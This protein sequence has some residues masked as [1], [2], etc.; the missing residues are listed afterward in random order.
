MSAA[1][2]AGWAIDGLIASTLLLGAVMLVRRHV[3][4]GF[5]AQLA[6]C[7]WVLPALRLLL[8]PLPAGWW[9]ASADAPITRAG[10]TVT[11][12]LAH[13]LA[14]ASR[15]VD[16]AASA[17]SPSML[18][19]G[20]WAAGA[21]LF[22]GWHL[23]RHHRFCRAV[24]RD[25]TLL[26][27]RD[28]IRIVASPAA[29]GPIAFGIVRR[30]VAFP[31][32]FATRYDAGEQALALRHELGHHRRRDL[33]ANWAAL[34]V[35]ALHWFNPLAWAAFRAF[36][37]DQEL[38][39]DAGVLAGCSADERHAYARAIVK[40]AH[41][42]FGGGM[43]A[44]HLHTVTDLKGRL[45]MLAASRASRRRLVAGAATVT[46]LTAA[47][48][49]LT[50]SGNAAERIGAT[51]QASADAPAPAAPTPPAD[52]GP[53]GGP[54]PVGPTGAGSG[55]RHVET[56]RT[57]R[58]T[59]VVVTENG[60]TR[61]FEGAEAERYLAEHRIAVPAPPAPPAPPVSSTR[62]MSY[63]Y[64]AG[65]GSQQ[66]DVRD[67]PEMV[68]VRCGTAGTRPAAMTYAD[69]TGGKRK[70]VVC[71]DRIAAAQR[72]AEEVARAAVGNARASLAV[73]RTAIERDANLSAEQR[74]QALEGIAQAEAELRDP[75]NN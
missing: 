65:V 52:A 40:A 17:P 35:L 29:P 51:L 5:G 8:P 12:Y 30:H 62:R 37:A 57:R 31:A 38:A 72:D 70:M 7:L 41:P 68:E 33:L 21:L 9:Q 10:E 66:V 63:L 23:V 22:L 1:G 18:L 49:G 50:A 60:R 61:T 27:V 39:N 4:R 74:A 47:G 58:A 34:V 69:D 25:A 54:A 24:L 20:A 44:C 67:V 45:K 14:V 73:A 3:R 26:E 71:I 11:I 2:L 36:R 53:D 16:V 28:G 55:G 75:A 19:N 32:D 46:L 42:Q 43:T 59:H 13:P 6:Y 15:P 48:L 64:N 56:T